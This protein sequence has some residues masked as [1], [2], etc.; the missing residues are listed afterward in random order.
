MCAGG[1]YF[2]GTLPAQR[3]T[4]PADG[5]SGTDH[6][7]HDCN[8]FAIDIEVLGRMLDGVSINPRLFKVRKLTTTQTSDLGGSSNGPLIRA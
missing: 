3:V 6:I 2:C 8:H 4:S 7:I 1:V 5:T